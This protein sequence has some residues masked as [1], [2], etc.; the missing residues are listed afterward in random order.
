MTL[1]AKV[2]K[3]EEGKTLYGILDSNGQCST[4]SCEGCSCSTKLKTI[5]L[6]TD[7]N[8][9]VEVG[10]DV[11]IQQN[12]RYLFHFALVIILPLIVLAGIQILPS[13]SAWS[14]GETRLNA[15]SMAGG[16]LTF[17]LTS[18]LIYLFRDKDALVV[19]PKGTSEGQ[20]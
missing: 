18:V 16:F 15:L 2:L 17:I 1:D 9:S 20:S 19:T 10:M 7:A 6:P 5:S 11:E 14:P 13:F 3:I 8:P 12:R 4:G